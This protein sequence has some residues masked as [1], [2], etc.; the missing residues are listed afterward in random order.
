MTGTRFKNVLLTRMFMLYLLCSCGVCLFI[1]IDTYI[2]CSQVDVSDSH[3][4]Q[5]LRSLIVCKE[6][7]NC[8][9]KFMS[10]SSLS[11][12]FAIP[13]GAPNFLATVAKF[14]LESDSLHQSRFSADIYSIVSLFV[15]EFVPD[16]TQIFH[17]SL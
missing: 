3:L 14:Q 4:L 11:P 1:H 16:I 15:P 10:N 8:P 7:L 2:H 12:P 13:G 5:V 6:S 9:E 17:T